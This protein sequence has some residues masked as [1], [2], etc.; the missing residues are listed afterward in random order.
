MEYIFDTSTQEAVAGR[1]VWSTE[2][3]LGLHRATQRKPVLKNKTN[4]NKD[5]L[6]RWEP[7]RESSDICLCSLWLLLLIQWCL[8]NI[9]K[10]VLLLLLIIMICVCVCV[11]MQITLYDSCSEVRGQPLGLFFSPT[12]VF[13][14]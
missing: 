2:C 10:I 4:Q 12:T 1:S 13:R 14:D 9:L 11:F 6:I 3:I 8:F 5:R 7:L